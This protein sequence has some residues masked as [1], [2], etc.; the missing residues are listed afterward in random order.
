MEIQ[1]TVVEIIHIADL[2]DGQMKSVRISIQWNYM[3]MVS[4]FPFIG[5]EHEFK[6]FESS[7]VS[8]YR[9]NLVQ[10]EWSIRQPN[11]ELLYNYW[12]E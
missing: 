6:V 5:M 12:P 4:L 3:T 11:H 2:S 10:E 8:Q 1:L 7:G 9:G